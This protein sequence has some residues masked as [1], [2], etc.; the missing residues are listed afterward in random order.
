MCVCV[1]KRQASS[2]ARVLS[3]VSSIGMKR[4]EKTVSA[5]AFSSRTFICISRTGSRFSFALRRFLG[6]ASPRILNKSFEWIGRC[7]T[8]T[9]KLKFTE[10]RVCVCPRIICT[11]LVIR[12]KL[13]TF[14]EIT[15]EDGIC[16][17]VNW[18]LYLFQRRNTHF[19]VSPSM[20]NNFIQRVS[21]LSFF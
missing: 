3:D 20:M 15:E 7:A 2:Y 9:Q 12:R 10:G 8:S 13:Y 11:P 17:I 4:M 6:N 5:T 14:I 1:S 19:L 16:I 21:F 18:I